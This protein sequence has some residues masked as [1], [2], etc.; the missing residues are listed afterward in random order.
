MND[1]NEALLLAFEDFDEDAIKDLIDRGADPNCARQQGM[2]DTPLLL[3]IKFHCEL[4]FIEYLVGK[5]ANVNLKNAYSES[6]ILKASADGQL[7][8]VKF[9]LDCGANPN[10]PSKYGST[11]MMWAAGRGQVDVIRLLISRGGD[12]YAKNDS[13]E[14]IFYFAK[15]ASTSDDLK[16]RELNEF[17]VSLI[18][19]MQLDSVLDSQSNTP[20]G[21]AF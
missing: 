13:G 3:A 2:M 11:P 5:G 12:I 20:S 10:E 9:L 15:N 19:Q 18:E 1:L 16:K 14:D 8:V 4:E 7:S 17:L 21:I 6:P